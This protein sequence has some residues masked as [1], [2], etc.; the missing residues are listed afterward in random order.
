MS[1]NAESI[2]RDSNTRVLGGKHFASDR[3]ATVIEDLNNRKISGVDGKVTLDQNYLLSETG[4]AILRDTVEDDIVDDAGIVSTTQF[5]NTGSSANSASQNT[6]ST[7]YTDV[8][9]PQ[10]T[11]TLDRASEV[12]VTTTLAGSN[13]SADTG[14]G[15]VARMVVS[16]SQAGEEMFLPGVP[17]GSGVAY[18]T[19]SAQ[20]IVSLSAG[21]HTF[22]LQFKADAAGTA[23]VKNKRV[24]YIVL[25][26]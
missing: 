25:G 6:T 18:M 17:F 20:A 24:T 14:E 2:K 22:K 4:K 11:I 7:S 10:V 16:G 3:E 8:T 9:N 5:D 15:C 13:S 12:L 1:S 19:A 21:S 26:K 23:F